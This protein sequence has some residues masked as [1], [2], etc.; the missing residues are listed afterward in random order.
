MPKIS[1]MMSTTGVL[2]FDS[3]YTTNVSTERPSCLTLTHSRWRG[4][5]S[6]LALAQSC[7]ETAC[8]ASKRR[9]NA[10]YFMTEVPPEPKA[11]N[12]SQRAGTVREVQKLVLVSSIYPY[13]IETYPPTPRCFAK[14]VRKRLKTKEG[15]CQKAPREKKSTPITEKTKLH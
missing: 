14:R 3:G 7:A 10:M 2:L 4:D 11:W 12:L 13:G 6:S 9:I 1:W 15:R 8:A 5:F